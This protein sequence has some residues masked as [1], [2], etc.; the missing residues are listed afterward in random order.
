MTEARQ[1][2]DEGM[3][4]VGSTRRGLSRKWMLHMRR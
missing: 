4:Q 2:S 1:W 3:L